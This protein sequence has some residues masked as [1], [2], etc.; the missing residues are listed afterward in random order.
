M[1]KKKVPFPKINE[2]STIKVIILFLLD[3]LKTPLSF[4]TLTE[5]ILWDGSVNYFIFADC[6]DN[7]AQKGAVDKETV[8]K[9]T[10]YSINSFGKDILEN[11]SDLLKDSIKTQML[12]SATRLLAFNRRGNVVKSEVKPLENGNELIC[13]IK[14]RDNT[15]LDL[16]LYLDKK[17]EADKMAQRF[18]EKAEV[19]F[20]G[21]MALL[22]G[23]AKFIMD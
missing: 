17:D 12:R 6:L 14:D 10:L 18:D 9:E 21:V 8:G 13:T 16:H 22:S 3:E 20:R 19:I 11:V 1:S 23:E 15:L 5:I 4:Q 2:E 7:L